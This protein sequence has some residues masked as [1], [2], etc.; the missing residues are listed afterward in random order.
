MFGKA[1]DWE[2]VTEET[3]KRVRKVKLLKGENKRLR[4]LSEEEAECLLSNFDK[5][6]RPIV[7]TALHTGMRRGEIF[8]LT[9][10]GVDLKNRLILLDRTKNGKSGKFRLTIR[11]L[12]LYRV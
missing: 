9:W 2:L 1:L 10:N 4:Y 6:L 11:F 7:I 5:H 12:R 8:G 3:V